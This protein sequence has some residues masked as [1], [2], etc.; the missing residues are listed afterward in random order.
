MRIPAPKHK[1]RLMWNYRIDLKGKLSQNDEIATIMPRHSQSRKM[2]QQEDHP[3]QGFAYTKQP[4]GTPTP[5]SPDSR[6]SPPGQ[7]P[8][9]SREVP[10]VGGHSL[11]RSLCLHRRREHGGRHGG[12]RRGS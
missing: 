4:I 9:G 10:L 11:Y 6:W 12:M 8:R 7:P 1:V 3:R 2:E 5:R